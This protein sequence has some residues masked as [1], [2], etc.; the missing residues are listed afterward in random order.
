MKPATFGATL[1]LAACT[2]TGCASAPPTDTPGRSWSSLHESLR[3]RAAIAVNERTARNVILF[4]GDGMGVA[5]VTATRIFDGQS[6]GEPGEENRLAFE[7]CPP[8]SSTAARSS[9][10]RMPPRQGRRSR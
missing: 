5:T 2:A 9:L 4:V 7:R 10:R 6:R 1:A 3:D 8:P